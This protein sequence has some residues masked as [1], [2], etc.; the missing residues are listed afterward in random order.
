MTERI[1]STMNEFLQLAREA[2][3]C[4][5]LDDNW[6]P[7]NFVVGNE[8]CDLDS[9]ISALCLAYYYTNQFTADIPIAVYAPL[10]NIRRSELPLKGELS[11]LC[12][13]Y[14]INADLLICR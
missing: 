13:R 7:V 2:I 8:A 10:L 1:L 3:D 9:A 14:N 5:L 11:Y 4:H 12:R 6:R